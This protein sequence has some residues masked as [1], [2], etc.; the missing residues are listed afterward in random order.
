MSYYLICTGFTALRPE[1]ALGPQG[2]TR[3]EH[4]LRGL[5][6][7]Q[8]QFQTRWG[9]AGNFTNKTCCSWLGCEICFPGREIK[10]PVDGCLCTQL[11][12]LAFIFLSE[13]GVNIQLLSIAG[14]PL[15]SGKEYH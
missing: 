1:Q 3:E 13:R 10:S 7:V 14:V 12:L 5:T 2:Q 11:S 4:A 9:I 6:T 15:R 8:I